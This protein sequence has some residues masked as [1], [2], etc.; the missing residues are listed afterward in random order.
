MSPSTPV[1]RMTD[2]LQTPLLDDRQYYIIILPNKLEALLVQDPETDKASA[3]LDVN[4]EAFSNNN[5][6]PSIAY[7][8]KHIS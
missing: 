6:I 2:Q 5:K 7:T 3:A 8:V 1:E 4:V